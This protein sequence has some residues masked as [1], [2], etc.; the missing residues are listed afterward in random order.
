LWHYNPLLENGWLQWATDCVASCH[1]DLGPMQQVVAVREAVERRRE[2]VERHFARDAEALDRI[3]G[4]LDRVG[5]HGAEH[6][7]GYAALAVQLMGRRHCPVRWNVAPPAGDPGLELSLVGDQGREVARFDAGGRLTARWLETQ[8]GRHMLDAGGEAAPASSTWARFAAAVTATSELPAAPCRS[9]WSSAL[10]AMELADTIELS[11]RKHRMI[12]VH[13][14]QLTEQLAFRGTMAAVGCAVL[15]VLPPL[16]LFA[17]WGAGLLGFSLASYWP[18]A[19]L[20]LLTVFLLV[21]LL[22]K[23]V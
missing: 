20:G 12:D 15:L 18:H 17:G 1:P 2:D 4:G 16:L 10:H 11:L 14:Q 7:A 19:L 23:L 8:S 21:Q 9:T 22:P 5:A 3:V 13:Q 6:D